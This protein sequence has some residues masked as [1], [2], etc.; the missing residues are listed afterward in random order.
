MLA[1]TYVKPRQPLEGQ[2]WIF[3][4]GAAAD[5]EGLSDALTVVVTRRMNFI[6]LP[7]RSA[8]ACSNPSGEEQ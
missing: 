5:P 7:Q 2:V 6:G 3:E 1:P 4:V 8:A